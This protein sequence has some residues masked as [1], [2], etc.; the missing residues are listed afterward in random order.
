MSTASQSAWAAYEIHGRAVR[1]RY[2]D[3]RVLSLGDRATLRRCASVNEIVLEGAFWRLV[4]ELPYSLRLRFAPAVL[5]FPCCPA[6]L[7]EQF[8]LGRYFRDTL[9]GQD[10][11]PDNARSLR[12]RQLIAARDEGELTLRL[13]RLLTFSKSPVDWGVVAA[14]LLRWND[15]ERS[16]GFVLRRWAQDYYAELPAADG[17]PPTS[18]DPST[19]DASEGESP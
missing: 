1:A 2:D 9:C 17:I 6:K 7:D 3:R 13:R 18:T 16:R 8:R 12:F 5:L 10:K 19:S 11:R 4:E 14:D 15:G